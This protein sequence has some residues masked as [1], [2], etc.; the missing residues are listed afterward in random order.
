M[1]RI[2]VQIDRIC[3]QIN[4]IL[5]QIYRMLVQL[6]RIRAQLERI[7]VKVEKKVICK[8]QF[9]RGNNLICNYFQLEYV[10]L[11]RNLMKPYHSYL[12][13]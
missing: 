1:Y 13:K 9:N 12:I 7:R 8:G 10:E 4:R 6:D 5:V 2:G 3:V 11:K